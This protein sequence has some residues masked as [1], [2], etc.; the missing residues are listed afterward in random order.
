MRYY[1][2]KSKFKRLGQILS[3]RFERFNLSESS[4]FSKV[5][6]NRDSIGYWITYVN[7]DKLDYE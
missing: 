4:E 5:A 3:F 7:L 6:G 2:V 1:N